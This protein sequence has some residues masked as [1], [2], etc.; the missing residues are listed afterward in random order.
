M[1]LYLF[2]C[3]WYLDMDGLSLSGGFTTCRHLR[4]RT[5]TNSRI[6]YSVLRWWL[7]DYRRKNLPPGHDALF[8][9][10]EARDLLYYAQSHRHNGF[11][12]PTCR[13]TV[14]HANHQTTTAVPSRRI[15]HTPGLQWGDLLP[16]RGGG[17]STL[18]AP[19]RVGHPQGGR[20]MD[21]WV[22]GW[23]DVWMHVY[24]Y[25]YVYVYIAYVYIGAY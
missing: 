13:S 22:D 1:Y 18:T 11:E 12:Q 9:R 23:M 15:K 7:V 4:A 19:P 2:I 16:N 21:G 8:S 6:T 20:W 24:M 14:E 5:Y 10:Q 25:I 3:K 17:S